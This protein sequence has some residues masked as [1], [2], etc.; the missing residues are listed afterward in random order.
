MFKIPLAQ[1]DITNL[2]EGAV[3]GVLKTSTLSLGPQLKEFEKRI[4]RYIGVKY[5]IGVNSGTSALHLIIRSL[6]IKD[7]DEVI[8]TPFSFIAS[9][10]CILYERAKP[11]FV[12]ISDDD[13]N[14]DSEQI[15]EKITKKTKAIM[16]IHL[17]GQPCNMK[18]II[19]IAEEYNLT[20]I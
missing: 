11:V 6:G 18:K 5:A 8:T 7:G 1:P 14:I 12:D 20:I 19:D 17:F 9:S 2:E 13:F 15:Q 10:N 4:A 16:P 3:L